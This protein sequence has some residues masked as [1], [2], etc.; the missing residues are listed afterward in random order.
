MRN[1]ILQAMS[2][3]RT[4]KSLDFL[5]ELTYGGTAATARAAAKA[6]LL[7]RH[8]PRILGRLQ[9]IAGKRKEIADV[10]AELMAEPSE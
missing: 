7:H 4:E 6:L 10:L 8:D 1:R 3:S 2:T 9:E 5:F